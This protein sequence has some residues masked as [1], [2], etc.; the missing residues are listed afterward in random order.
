MY[1]YIHTPK[2]FLCIIL[3]APID[4][5]PFLISFSFIYLQICVKA[6]SN[7]LTTLSSRSTDLTFSFNAIY[8]FISSFSLYLKRDPSYQH[9]S[10]HSIYED[11][12]MRHQSK[13]SHIFLLF[14]SLTQ[15][16]MLLL[17]LLLLCFIF[18]LLFFV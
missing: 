8:F 9:P 2:A 18:F 11:Y 7:K 10:T 13:I 16:S 4:Y 5:V 15:L 3:N 12:F 1:S 6:S 14:F 17:L